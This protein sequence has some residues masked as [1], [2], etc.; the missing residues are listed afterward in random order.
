MF[1]Y[2]SKSDEE[3]LRGETSP[4]SD[5]GSIETDSVAHA[6]VLWGRLGRGSGNK[7]VLLGW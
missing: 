2:R 3:L 4:K 5:F 6:L 1:W 7:L